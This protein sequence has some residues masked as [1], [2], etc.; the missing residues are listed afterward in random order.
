MAGSDVHV[1]RAEQ[2]LELHHCSHEAFQ[3]FLEHLELLK[4]VAQCHKYG[5]YLWVGITDD[6]VKHLQGFHQI[7]VAAVVVLIV[8]VVKSERLGARSSFEVIKAVQ[9][10]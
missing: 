10:L 8:L 4:E 7:A 3:G 9:F 2:L 5:G 1:V 6:E